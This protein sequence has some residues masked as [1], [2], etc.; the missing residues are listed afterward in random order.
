MPRIVHEPSQ[1]KRRSPVGEGPLRAFP[2]SIQ[3]RRWTALG[4]LFLLCGCQVTVEEDG[5]ESGAL[6][7][8]HVSREALAALEFTSQCQRQLTT[9][10]ESLFEQAFALVQKYQHDVEDHIDQELASGNPDSYVAIS[11]DR[12]DRWRGGVA[13]M[14][15]GDVKVAC[16][17]NATSNRCANNPGTFGWTFGLDPLFVW[18]RDRVHVCIDNVRAQAFAGGALGLTADTLAHELMHHVDGFE[19]HGAGGFTN[20]A[21]PD[22][23]AET[24]GVAVEHLIMTPDLRPTITSMTHSFAGSD[25]GVF[26]DVEVENLNPESDTNLIAFSGTRRNVTSTLRLRVDG[27]TADIVSVSPLNGGASRVER[28]EATIPAYDPGA[29]SEYELSVTADSGNVLFESDELN[30]D[31]GTN[32][33]TAVDLAIAVEVAAEPVCHR[34]ELRTDVYPPGY[35]NWFEIPYRVRVTNVDRKTD[36]ATSDVV[37]MYQDMWS[38][39]NLTSQQEVWIPALAPLETEEVDFRLDVPTDSTCSGPVGAVDVWFITDWNATTIFDVDRSNNVVSLVIDEDYWKPDYVVSVAGGS[40]NGAGAVGLSAVATGG[41]VPYSVRNIGPA[42]AGKGTSI[43]LSRT[44]VLD[45][46]GAS[47]FSAL[48][49]DIDPG[50]EQS[51]AASVDAGA[52]EAVTYTIETDHAGAID[53]ADEDNNTALA[54]LHPSP[55]VLIQCSDEQIAIIGCASA[56][57]ASVAC[58]TPCRD[59][60]DLTTCGSF[61]DCY[62][63]EL[64]GWAPVDAAFPN[65]GGISRTPREGWESDLIRDEL[66]PR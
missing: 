26:I 62:Y 36:A 32:Y 60:F 5:D 25:H 2:C 38:E 4:G 14:G 45:G 50:K 12:M 55:A 17:Y 31:D 42:R 27:V 53:E 46:Y 43:A 48:T 7:A 47:V 22:T 40:G 41:V 35:Y 65:G 13:E 11:A 51:F 34:L 9:S 18:A 16:E 61:G 30:N 6:E 59:L 44:R 29:D 63:P 37:M 1:D 20:P 39:S 23:A 28:L 49:L 66:Q 19:G 57:G 8:V 33:S 64:D 21:N 56:C 58:E 24:I 15:R 54:T 3:R 52:C 10:D